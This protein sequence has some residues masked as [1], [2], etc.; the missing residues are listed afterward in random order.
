MPKEES[1]KRVPTE[2][3]VPAPV[4]GLRLDGRERMAVTG[5]RD[6]SG[7]DENTVLLQTDLGELSIRGE[8][9]HID[10]IDLESGNLELRGKVRELSYD[11]QA[12]GGF[13]SRL[14]G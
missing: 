6:V 14:F 4:H 7:F 10:R 2:A 8:Q 5:V 13:L 3:L 9:L 12:R 11:E 1:N